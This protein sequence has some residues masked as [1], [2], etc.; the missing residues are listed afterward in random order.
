M[1]CLLLVNGLF[2]YLVYGLFVYSII[3]LFSGLWIIC[4][5]LVY[6]LFV[7]SLISISSSPSEILTVG[8]SLG[9]VLQFFYLS[10]M[11]LIFLHFFSLFWVI[12]STLSSSW[13]FIFLVPLLYFLSYESGFSYRIISNYIPLMIL[14]HFMLMIFLTQ[15]LCFIGTYYLCSFASLFYK[16]LIPFKYFFFFCLLFTVC[17]LGLHRFW[18][19]MGFEPC[20]SFREKWWNKVENTIIFAAVFRLHYVSEGL[21][22]TEAWECSFTCPCFTWVQVKALCQS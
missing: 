7:Y 3:C 11:L 5:L 4:L 14:I 22:F 6:G 18:E 16:L 2:V 9:S 15:Q 19:I 1:D 17:I 10:L 12:S 20:Q 21:F 13:S 8:I